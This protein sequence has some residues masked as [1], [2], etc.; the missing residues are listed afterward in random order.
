MGLLSI[1]VAI[2][3]TEKYL[4]KCCDSLKNQTFH[5]LEIIL[6]DD[7]STDSSATICDKYA[8]EDKRFHVVHKKNGGLPTA[9]LAGIAVATGDYIGFVDSDDWVEKETYEKMLLM[10]KN[11]SE[12]DICIGG[13]VCDLEETIKCSFIK[14][15]DMLL[16]SQEA[17][18]KMFEGKIFNCSLTDKV[19][20]R[21]LFSGI[22][23][24]NRN[25]S[26]GEDTLAN[27]Q[28]FNKAE[29]ISYSFIGGYH[30]NVV[31]ENS[32]MHQALSVEQFIYMDIYEN[33]LKEISSNDSKLK[34]KVTELIITFSIE[35]LYKMLESDQNFK[36]YY[37][38]YQKMLLYYIQVYG[39]NLNTVQK[40]K[41]KLVIQSYEIAIELEKMRKV[42]IISECKKQITGQKEIYI[43]G[44]GRIARECAEIFNVFNYKYNGFI[45][46]NIKEKSF[47]Y[48]KKVY[49]YS[50]IK[51]NITPDCYIILALN[52][53][54]TEEV[55]SMLKKDGIK[56]YI[57]IGKYSLN[58]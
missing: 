24:W 28:L 26:Y 35:Y 30:Y 8:K 29:R 10:V 49:F 18:L 11:N 50:N 33:I 12:I 43:Y 3:N 7:G 36:E 5:D 6:V 41:Y 13:Y 57:D 55:T 38:Y 58:Y 17:L 44:T 45:V 32:M 21:T 19:Y 54:H 1:I 53:K 46:T 39:Y 25:I 34:N 48:N 37:Q 14:E 31:N 15:S 47:F 4:V 52:K 56:S 27:W 40:R 51:R 16:E 42:Q 2:Y 22:T 9:R 23:A 20:K